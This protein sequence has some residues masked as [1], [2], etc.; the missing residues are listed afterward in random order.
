MQAKATRFFTNSAG[1]LL[2]AV[3]LAM[4]IANWASA[5]LTQPHDPVLAVSMDNLFWIVGVMA[6]VVAMICLFSERVWLKI[7]LILW[8]AVNLFAYQIGFFLKGSHAGFSVYLTSLAEA[9]GIPPVAAELILQ[10]IMAY[11]LFGG[12]EFLAYKWVNRPKTTRPVPVAPVPTTVKFSC[13]NPGCQQHIMVDLSCSGRQIQCPA[14]G[15]V[16]IVPTFTFPN[17]NPPAK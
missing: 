11:L 4:F 17:P 10:I 3:A 13:I 1:T 7:T 15:T 16:L 12:C 5:G 8:L 2:L 6:L 14:C 9:F